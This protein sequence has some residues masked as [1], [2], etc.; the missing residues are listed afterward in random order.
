MPIIKDEDRIYVLTASATLVKT[1]LSR[2][3]QWYRQWNIESHSIK[4]TLVIIGNWFLRVITLGLWALLVE[5]VFHEQARRLDLEAAARRFTADHALDGNPPSD[6]PIY[7]KSE[8]QT[9]NHVND[10]V[11][12]Q[13]MI[14]YRRRPG[15]YNVSARDTTSTVQISEKA[16]AWQRLF[17]D[18]ATQNRIPVNIA[19]DGANLHVLDD[20]GRVHYRKVLFEGRGHAEIHRATDDHG[21]ISDYC[22]AFDLDPED[23]ETYVAV[24]VNQQMLWAEHWYNFPFLSRIVNWFLPSL[25]LEGLVA[26]SNRGR[27][28]DSYSDVAGKKHSTQT[29]CT[30]TYQCAVNATELAKYDPWAPT[31]SQVHFYFPENQDQCFIASRIDASAS[32]LAVLGYTVDKK[33]QKGRLSLLAQLCDIDVLGGDP[34]FS[35]AYQSELDDTRPQSDDLIILPDLVDNEGW[36]EITLPV[37]AKHLYNGL[38]VIQQRGDTRLIRLA[39]Q[40]EHGVDGY[41][42]RRMP[43]STAWQFVPDA[44]IHNKI[45]MPL[46]QQCILPKGA[47]SPI[48]CSGQLVTQHHQQKIKVHNFGPRAYHSQV[49]LDT[50]DGCSHTL[51]LHRRWGLGTFLGIDNVTQYELVLPKS[52]KAP[53]VLG[54]FGG[55]RVIPVSTQLGWEHEQ[56]IVTISA[57]S[58]M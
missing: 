55:K 5:P 47:A 22:V 17:F 53:G 58:V 9:F 21:P 50:D 8:T 49:I 40:N 7:F 6:T 13:G 27:F 19:A 48:Q 32:Y 2:V 43:E 52:L 4:D 39:G 57:R 45:Q 1:P 14:W 36:Q 54:L 35:Y 46:V 30:T 56:P 23:K 26:H 24:D 3:I 15:L 28:S 37:Q 29:G 18:G 16:G 31:W 42:E 44:N 33:T 20:L 51:G 34:L 41:F 11:I 12:H 25:R 10:Y 38:T